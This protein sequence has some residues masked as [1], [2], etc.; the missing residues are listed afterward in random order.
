MTL[1]ATQDL[2][3]AVYTSSGDAAKLI[4]RL[5]R[6]SAFSTENVVCRLAVARSL[7]EPSVVGG[8][9]WEPAPDGKQVRGS[10]L[11]GR[12]DVAFALL[13]MMVRHQNRTLSLEELR[14]QVRLHWERGLRLL[15]AEIKEDDLDGL[16]LDYS[17]RAL[18]G[19]EHGTARAAQSP[20]T[21]LS[22]TFVGQR[23]A[24]DE[25]AAMLEAA[26]V[27]DTPR[28]PRPLNIVG[29]RGTGKTLI[30][31]AIALSLQ[32]PL[33]E[34]NAAQISSGAHWFDT[35][36]L[37]RDAQRLAAA[38]ESRDIAESHLGAAL[39]GLCAK[40]LAEYVVRTDRL[41][42]ALTESEQPTPFTRAVS[43]APARKALE[44]GV[45][46]FLCHAGEDKVSVARP[47]AEQLKKRTLGLA[48]RT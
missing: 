19:Q 24:K 43:D 20:R 45:D 14:G 34:L 27:G 40:G 31:K 26:S 35:L 5:T 17:S 32:L 3:N 11:L 48:G 16:L 23:R 21:V 2:M 28:L 42:E 39:V 44:T 15:S 33:V 25:L 13:A 46:V 4:R 38:A 6:L 37:L 41:L 47:I 8:E 36:T 9:S 12:R 7:A 18:L 29:P 1:D 10:T 30:S 22:A